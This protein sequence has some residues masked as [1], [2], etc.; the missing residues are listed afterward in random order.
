VRTPNSKVSVLDDVGDPDAP[1]GSEPWAKWML[2]QGKLRR[3]DL[4]RDVSGLQTVIRKLEKHAAW[5][6]LGFESQSSLCRDGLLL[7]DRAVELIRA[8]RPGVSLRAV[9]A[10]E[11]PKTLF[12]VG[13]PTKELKEKRKPNGA[14]STIRRGSTQTEYIAARIARDHPVILEKMKKGEFKS[15][16]QAGIA[17]GIVKVPTPYE[18]AVKAAEKLSKS[19]KKKLAKWLSEQE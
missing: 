8:A 15:V 7:D 13:P 4:D 17:A 19:E 16:R 12:P 14:N 5:K 6:T 2:G 10:A 18:A 11:N 3:G 1:P 9:L